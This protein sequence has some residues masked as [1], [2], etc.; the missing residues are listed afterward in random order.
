MT[1]R[2]FRTYLRLGKGILSA[3]EAHGVV[4]TMSLDEGNGGLRV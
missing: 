2:V 3:D 1:S 4:G